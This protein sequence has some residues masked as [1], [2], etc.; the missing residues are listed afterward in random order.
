MQGPDVVAP[1]Q[2]RIGRV[3]CFPAAL[4]IANHDGV[5]I[6]VVAF[7]PINVVVGDFERTD[8]FALDCSGDVDGRGEWI[9]HVGLAGGG[10][11][12]GL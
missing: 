11:R 4:E 7:D 9:S 8:R 6:V 1:G 10:F 12:P 5:D 3:G 2:R